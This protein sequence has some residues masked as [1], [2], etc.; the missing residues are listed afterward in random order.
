MQT[1]NNGGSGFCNAHAYEN[2][3]IIIN[4]MH[5]LDIHRQNTII[6]HWL[7]EEMLMTKGSLGF[8]HFWY[9]SNLH[10]YMSP[11][12]STVFIKAVLFRR[13]YLLTIF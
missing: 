11:N 2:I 12:K 5:L 9:I 10:K 13:L 3:L 8:F 4:T 1:R 6:Y 7:Q